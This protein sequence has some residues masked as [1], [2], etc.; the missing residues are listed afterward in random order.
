MARLIHRLTV[1]T[2]M[3]PLIRAQTPFAMNL[4]HASASSQ[5][6]T[7]PGF[8]A[9]TNAGSVAGYRD[10]ISYI[11]AGSPPPVLR[12]HA[13]VS[14][15]LFTSI[16]STA[17]AGTLCYANSVYEFEGAVPGNAINVRQ[18]TS[19]NVPYTTQIDSDPIF[20]TFSI[21][22]IPPLSYY[23][24]NHVDATWH[25]DVPYNPA[26][27]GYRVAIM[28]QASSGTPGSGGGFPNGASFSDFAA[29]FDARQHLTNR[30]YDRRSFQPDVRFEPFICSGPR[31]RQHDAG[32]LTLAI[33]GVVHRKTGRARRH[34]GMAGSSLLTGPSSRCREEAAGVLQSHR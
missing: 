23:S 8:G 3:R 18:T 6:D 9:G 14:G 17:G 29:H 15:D 28:L 26:T 25:I 16:G 2:R 11:G 32:A 33:A 20:D 5:S 22:P 10:F 1:P 21:S 30:R 19:G 27:G 12:F 24:A 13:G 34:T 7:Y 4:L 31:A